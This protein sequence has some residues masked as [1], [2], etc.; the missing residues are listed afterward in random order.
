LEIRPTS[1]AQ[2]IPEQFL[3]ERNKQLKERIALDLI[4][5]AQIR[6]EEAPDAAK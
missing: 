1:S 2:L 5:G 4:D 6:G 3:S